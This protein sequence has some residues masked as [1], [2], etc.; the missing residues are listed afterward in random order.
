M[1]DKIRFYKG[2]HKVKVVTES[3]GYYIV[4]ALEYKEADQGRVIGVQWH[5]EFSDTLKDVVIPADRLINHFLDQA[6]S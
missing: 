2:I 1:K 4:E 6:R 3:I 5:P